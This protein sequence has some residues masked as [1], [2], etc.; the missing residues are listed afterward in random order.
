[1]YIFKYTHRKPSIYSRK[2]YIYST[3][4]HG[5]CTVTLYTHIYTYIFIRV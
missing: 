2:P 4:S 1:M 3:T 5:M